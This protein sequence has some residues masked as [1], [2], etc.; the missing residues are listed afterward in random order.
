MWRRPTR[1]T[2]PWA[3]K[4]SRRCN[5]ERDVAAIFC[6]GLEPGEMLVQQLGPVAEEK[7][8]IHRIPMDLTCPDSSG[9]G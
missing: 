9:H 5:I 4:V 3:A 2:T 6:C 1:W 7:A 8:G